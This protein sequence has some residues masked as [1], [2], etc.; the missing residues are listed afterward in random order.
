MKIHGVEERD[1]IQ[2]KHLENLFKEIIG[3]NFS[4]LE[5]I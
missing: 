1:G 5:K 3:E 2:T 4:L